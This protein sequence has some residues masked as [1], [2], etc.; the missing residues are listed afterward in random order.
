MLAAEDS[1]RYLSIWMSPVL[2]SLVLGGLIAWFLPVIGTVWTGVAYWWARKYSGWIRSMA[3]GLF[4][5]SL[6]PTGIVVWSEA[7]ASAHAG[8]RLK[9]F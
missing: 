7:T 6:F 9:R 8:T 5:L 1:V 4:L 3:L 2:K